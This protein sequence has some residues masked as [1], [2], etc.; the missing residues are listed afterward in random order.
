MEATEKELKPQEIANMFWN[1]NDIYVYLQMDP[2]IELIGFPKI[3]FSRRKI[4][5]FETKENK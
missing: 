4:R 5:N 3:L 2:R 1:K